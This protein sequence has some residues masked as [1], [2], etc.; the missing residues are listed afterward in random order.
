[1]GDVNSNSRDKGRVCIKS[2]NNVVIGTLILIGLMGGLTVG[3]IL[4]GIVFHKVYFLLAL[5]TTAAAYFSFTVLR[6][7]A[8]RKA[9]MQDAVYNFD[10]RQYVW[11]LEDTRDRLMGRLLQEK[12]C[13]WKQGPCNPEEC[14]AMSS[15]C[16][17]AAQIKKLKDL[18]IDVNETS[19]IMLNVRT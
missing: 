1:M 9:K 12:I 15:N 14:I 3:F 18:E 5:I 6:D 11:Q 13:P 4:M 2:L 17:C 19:K 7:A 8:T 16:A 10:D